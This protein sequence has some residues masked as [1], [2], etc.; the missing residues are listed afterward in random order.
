MNLRLLSLATATFALGTGSFIF[1]GQLEVL[2]ADLRIDPG[3][4]GQ[5]QTAYVLSAAISGPLLAFWIG[6]RNPKRVLQCALAFVAILNLLCWLAP[7]FGSLMVLRVLLGACGAVGGPTAAAIGALLVP[8]ERRGSALALILGGMTFAFIAGVPIGTV[9]GASFGWRATF[10]FAATLAACALA[11]ISLTV[12]PV[13]AEPVGEAVRKGK[14]A[15]GFFGVIAPIVA[16]TFLV[17][18]AA[19][20][21]STYSVILVRLQTGVTGA[22]MG[23]FQALAGVGSVIGLTIGARLGNRGRG[24]IG[25]AGALLALM[26]ATSVQFALIHVGGEPSLANIIFASAA[27]VVSS[28]CMFAILPMIQQR[29][30]GVTGADSRLALTFNASATS[31]GQGFGSGIG[32]VIIVHLGIAFNLVTTALLAFIALLFWWIW[33]RRSGL[34]GSRSIPDSDVVPEDLPPA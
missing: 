32:G 15:R 22:G 31:F 11:I 33:A 16:T 5:L 26:L 34:A 7:G 8:P 1:G 20:T 4:A 12:P 23:A 14:V 18:G 10:F 27:G 30:V 25:V 2:A 19:M 6:K 24:D 21:S 9:I 29:L 3:A 13:A 17:F 28:G